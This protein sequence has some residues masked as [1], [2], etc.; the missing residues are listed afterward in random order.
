MVDQ[1]EWDPTSKAIIGA[2]I[3]IHR[4]FGPGVFERVY[5]VYL[6]HELMQKG[7]QVE[8]QVRVAV[9]YEGLRMEHAY[10]LDLLVNSEVV[11]E[12]KAVDTLLPIHHAQLLSYLRLS[13][14]RVGLLINFHEKL[15]S[16]GLKRILNG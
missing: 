5:E 4:H 8:R 9:E 6:A 11:V 12:I 1:K 13:G 3:K 2:A 15:L 10:R 14:H 16:R 7:V